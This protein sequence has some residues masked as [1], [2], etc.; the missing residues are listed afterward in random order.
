MKLNRPTNKYICVY[1]CTYIYVYMCVDMYIEAIGLLKFGEQVCTAVQVLMPIAGES[2]QRRLTEVW[3]HGLEGRGLLIRSAPPVCISALAVHIIVAEISS[4]TAGQIQESTVLRQSQPHVPPTTPEKSKLTLHESHP[5]KVYTLYTS[6]RR[7][8]TAC[9]SAWGCRPC[10]FLGPSGVVY[11]NSS[12][13][14][15]PIIT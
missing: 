13:V 8:R 7:T 14:S 15:G 5:L 12:R 6:R 4:I 9:A 2:L 10:P 11:K 3:G 1:V